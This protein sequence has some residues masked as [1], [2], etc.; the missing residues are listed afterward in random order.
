MRPHNI[1]VWE[2]CWL[3]RLSK[4]TLRNDIVRVW[5]IYLILC[6]CIL[7][8]YI[9][10]MSYNTRMIQI[11]CGAHL[12]STSAFTYINHGLVL[13]S[14][15]CSNMYFKLSYLTEIRPFGYWDGAQSLSGSAVDVATCN[16]LQ[17]FAESVTH[18]DEWIRIWSSNNGKS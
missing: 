18:S 9:V 1:K 12:L 2:L 16:A 11:Y 15:M 7:S 17:C 14:C 4:F 3:R 8:L 13:S 5:N 10:H 6:T